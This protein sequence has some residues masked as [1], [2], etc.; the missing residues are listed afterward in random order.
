MSKRVGTLLNP[1]VVRGDKIQ[2]GTELTSGEIWWGSIQTVL[3][4]YDGRPMYRP[5]WAKVDKLA[6]HWR[7]GKV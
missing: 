7:K 6:T 2:I 5:K 4:V 3:R 1:V